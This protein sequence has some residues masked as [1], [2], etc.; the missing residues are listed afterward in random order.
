M[1]IFN[2][3]QRERVVGQEI[4]NDDEQLM[5]KIEYPTDVKMDEIVAVNHKGQWL[6]ARVQTLPKV[7]LW[8]GIVNWYTA[9]TNDNH[10][11]QAIHYKRHV[12]K[13]PSQT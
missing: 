4:C 8:M 3:A 13:L 7:P 2:I 9:N 1:E 11:G 5:R 6:Y 10:G 12:R